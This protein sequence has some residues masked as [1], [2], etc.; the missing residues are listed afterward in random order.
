[1][2]GPGVVLELKGE[3]DDTSTLAVVGG[4]GRG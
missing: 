2:P 4:E 3:L 1:M